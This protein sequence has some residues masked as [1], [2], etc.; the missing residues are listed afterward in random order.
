MAQI[1]VPED[2]PLKIVNARLSE[3]NA[4][5]ADFLYKRLQRFGFLH[6]DAQRLV[7]Q[8][9]NVFGACMVALGHA[10]G[11]VTGV[12]RNYATALD[13]VLHVID[14]AR[15]ERRDGHVRSCC[16]K[17]RTLFVSDTAVAEFPD[18]PGTGADRA[19]VGSD[20]APVRRNAPRGAALALHFRQ[21]E[22]GALGENPRSGLDSGPA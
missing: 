2:A 20:G 5:Y 1:G 13:D 8:D 15:G 22:D 19:A 10:D 21:S 7:N 17:G 6:R 16:S 4:A 12:T 3:H 11:M 14:P 9:R 18:A